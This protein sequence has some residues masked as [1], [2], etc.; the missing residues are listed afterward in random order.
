[1]RDKVSKTA[2]EADVLLWLMILAS[3]ETHFCWT[4]INN[5]L[6]SLLQV[7]FLSY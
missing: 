4:T 2:G 1:M 5:K 7:P 6:A 3:C